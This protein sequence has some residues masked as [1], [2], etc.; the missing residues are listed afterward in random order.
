MCWVV[1]R[2]QK[3][4]CIPSFHKI[5]RHKQFKAFFMSQDQDPFIRHSHGADYLAKQSTETEMSFWWNLR[6]WLHWKLSFG[7]FLVQPMAA[8]LSKWRHF[9]FS[10]DRTLITMILT[11]CHNAR[12]SVSNHLPHD[13][14]LNR[15]FGR[16]SN[17][18]SKLRATGLCAGN[19]PGTGEF[20]AQMASNTEDVSIW[21]RHHV[22][23]NISTSTPKGLIRHLLFLIMQIVNICYCIDCI[24]SSRTCKTI[25]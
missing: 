21:W 19:S 9:C 16:R 4:I 8:I 20:P 5:E 13:C 18:T 15:L 12:D 10:E 17:K 1:W 6:H 2:K 3:Y 25:S 14:L 22:Y 24:Y 7:Q 23:W 11:W